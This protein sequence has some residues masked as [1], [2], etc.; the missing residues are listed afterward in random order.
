MQLRAPVLPSAMQCVA[1]ARLGP[2]LTAVMKLVT[3]CA[4][5]ALMALAVTTAVLATTAT[6]IAMVSGG[7]SRAR[8]GREGHLQAPRT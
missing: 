8:P 7:W 6:P 5:L 2:C 4:G 3:A 1:A